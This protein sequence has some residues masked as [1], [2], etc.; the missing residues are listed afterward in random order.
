MTTKPTQPTPP[1]PPGPR[2]GHA[3]EMGD[4]APPMTLRELQNHQQKSSD[5]MELFGVPNTRKDGRI[6]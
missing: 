3:I 4:G 1:L 6:K 5:W 2:E